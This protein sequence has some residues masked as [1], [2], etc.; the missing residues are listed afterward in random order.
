[1]FRTR[2]LDNS[3]NRLP[4]GFLNKFNFV[5]HI[6][7]AFRDLNQS[8][9]RDCGYCRNQMHNAFGNIYFNSKAMYAVM[10]HE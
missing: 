2:Q 10:E 5:L 8:R 1:M 4:L 3:P 9:A 7:Q 6:T